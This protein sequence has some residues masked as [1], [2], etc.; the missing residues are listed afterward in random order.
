MNLLDEVDKNG[1][2]SPFFSLRMFLIFLFLVSAKKR[3]FHNKPNGY[4][5]DNMV[6]Y[7]QQ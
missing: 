4:F 1:E 6:Y 3:D 7:I 5:A 2:T